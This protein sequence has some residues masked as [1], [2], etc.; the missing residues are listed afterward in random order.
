MANE[1]TDPKR[2]MSNLQSSFPQLRFRLF[3]GPEDY[4]HMVRIYGRSCEGDG[5]V[6]TV[7]VKDFE[8]YDHLEKKFDCKEVRLII[9]SDDDVI[10]FTSIRTVILDDGTRLYLHS[11]HLDKDWRIAGL[12][13]A[14]F[15]WNEAM[16]RNRVRIEGDAHDTMF[17]SYANEVSNEW[18]DILESEG[19]EPAT[20]LLEMLRPDLENIPDLPLPKGV[21]TRP[22]TPEHDRAIWDPAQEA[23]R[24]HRDFSEDYYNEDRYQ[25]WLKGNE[26]QPHLWQIAWAGDEVVGSIRS[27][28]REE[29]NRDLN[30][31]RG[32]TESIFVARDWRRKGIASALLARSLATLRDHGMRDATLDVDAYNLSGALRVYERMGFRKVYHF[33]FYRK[34]ITL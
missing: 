21:E 8:S 13:R 7:T 1:A 25:E 17:E 11:A 29:E 31:S 2:L 19:Y 22:A 28:I 34:P 9:E 5:F 16:I 30:R 15:A 4:G 32:H 10:G 27:F 18:K 33:V 23:A 26:F 6:Y 3:Q 24:D 20:H 14:M 12:R